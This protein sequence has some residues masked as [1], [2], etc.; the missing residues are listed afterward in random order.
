MTNKETGKELNHRSLSMRCMSIFMAATLTLSSVPALAY[1][2]DTP[3]DGMQAAASELVANNEVANTSATETSQEQVTPAQETSSSPSG[4]QSG[5]PA[6]SSKT[7]ITPAAT[8][9]A[10]DASAVVT[11]HD[12]NLL[13]AVCIALGKDYT[14]GVSVTE[15]DMASLTELKAEN[16][17]IKDLTGLYTYAVNLETLDLSGNDLSQAK[18]FQNLSVSKL[19]KMKTLD[20]SNCN[21]G[22]SSYAQIDSK[23]WLN[24][25]ESLES[26]D[27]SSNNL[28]GLLYL[29]YN[30]LSSMT[31]F[32]LGNLKQADF[33]KNNFSGFVCQSNASFNS[34]ERIDLSENRLWVNEGSKADGTEWY[35]YIMKVGY[36]KFDFLNQKPLTEVYSAWKSNDTNSFHGCSSKVDNASRTIDLGTVT[37]DSVTYSLSSFG[38]FEEL[39]VISNGWDLPKMVDNLRNQP[40]K[41]S[42]RTLIRWENLSEGE[43]T[44]E[45]KLSHASGESAVYT[46]KVTRSAMPTSTEESAGITD[47]NLH[48]SVCSALGLDASRAVTKGDMSKLTTLNAEGITNAEGIQYA[49]NLKSLELRGELSTLPDLGS[50]SSLTSLKLHGNYAQVT[51]L[52]KLSGLKT[53][54]LDGKDAVNAARN[55]SGIFGTPDL[56]GLTKLTA[57][58]VMST[59]MKTAPLVVSTTNLRNISISQAENGF[60]DLSS[61]KSKL[62]NLTLY[63]IRNNIMP[64]GLDF[65]DSLGSVILHSSDYPEKLFESFSLPRNASLEIFQDGGTVNDEIDISGSGLNMAMITIYN[66]AQKDTTLTIKGKAQDVLALSLVEDATTSYGTKYKLDEGLELNGLSSLMIAAELTDNISNKTIESLNQL[67]V[68]TIDSNYSVN[69]DSTIPAA[70]V[71][72]PTISQLTLAGKGSPL[73]FSGEV[74]FGSM[75]SLTSLTLVSLGSFLPERLPN[76][77]TTLSITNGTFSTLEDK[78][79][80]NVANLKTLQLKYCSIKDFPAKLVRNNQGLQ[81]LEIERGLFSEIPSDAFES[82][83]SL[84]TVKL[85]NWLKLDTDE[86]GS[87][88]PIAG[89]STQ[90]AIEALKENCPNAKVTYLAGTEHATNFASL[91]SITSEQGVVSGDPTTNSNLALYVPAG[92]R[93]VSFVVTGLLEDTSITVNGKE[94]KSGDVITVPLNSFSESVLIETHNDFVN[95]LNLS[96]DCVYSLDISQGSV[97]DSFVP[98]DGGVY[99]VSSSILKNGISSLSMAD[100]YFQ[101]NVTVRYTANAGAGKKYDIRVTTTKANWITDS[102]YQNA[103]GEYV[104]ADIVENNNASNTRVYRIYAASLDKPI[105]VS[106][107]VVPMGGDYPICDLS[108]DLANVVDISASAS[109]DTADLNAA[110]NKALEITEKNNVYTTDSW[111]ALNKALEQAQKIAELAVPTQVN[112]NAAKNALASAIDGLEVDESKLADKLALR[113]TIDDAKAIQKG[114]HTD[115]A[116]NALQE[117]IADAEGVFNTLEARQDEVDASVRSLNTAV[118]LFNSSGDASTLDKNNLKDGIYSITADMI[119]TDRVSK[120]MADNAINHTAKLEVKDG[121]YFITL[122]FRGITIENRFGYLKDLSYYTEGYT[123]GNYG[124]IEGDRVAAEVL[125]TQKDSDGN[126]VIDQYNDANSLYPDMVK[127]KLAPSAIAD[128]DG[129]V[130]LHV[131]VPIMESIATGNG[132]QDVLMKLDWSTLKTASADDPSFKPEDPIEQSPTVDVTDSATGVKVHADKGVFAEGTAIAV[133]AITSG[134]EHNNATKALS[135]VGKKFSFYKLQASDADGNEIAPNGPVSI[136]LPIPSG[137]DASKLAVYRINADGSKTLIQG[138]AENGLYTFTTRAMANFALVEKACATEL[139]S[140]KVNT[141]V[142]DGKNAIS[143]GNGS[144]A[145]LVALSGGSGSLSPVGGGSLAPID[146]EEGLIAEDENALASSLD[147]FNAANKEAGATSIWS[148]ILPALGA[149]LGLGLIGFILAAIFRRNKRSE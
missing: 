45:L 58:T 42:G 66:Q 140:N 34:L 107:C 119:K 120:S 16:A 74:D 77:L 130:P 132:D 37:T 1:A 139:G 28:S 79:Y 127:I 36:E 3:E 142:A 128:A 91:V 52:N 4:E 106:P 141:N 129:Y 60:P 59:N 7:S 85:G 33:S 32:K 89:S 122:D 72:K 69:G 26:I 9:G 125:S 143:K 71:C 56:S 54:V 144:R 27:L 49:T 126:D 65:F 13:K 64:E 53:L 10:E 115:T 70:L 124:T 68:L 61:V 83:S 31:P 17:G 25:F 123:Y 87:W 21:L 67:M 73:T 35:Q 88:S 38:N 41:N 90:A 82:S 136:S 12:E 148:T 102:K 76:S 5:A 11:F 40:S 138:K 98:S 86:S 39:S 109:V 110:I 104:T 15:N 117:A 47:P 113:T 147:E 118:T 51:G 103:E 99:N 8:E 30:D 146:E 46:L 133:S 55:T 145:S 57:L 84:R 62:R 105:K 43:N 50:L 29:G 95:P 121:E 114:N 149:V 22:G 94:Y 18:V 63:D 78:D 81:T 100:S 80:S 19:K 6:A 20:L 112:V 23:G 134:S 44:I 96:T 14:E 131:F 111:S 75:T 137:Y 97:M 135:D 108:L 2:T 92:T 93:E 101:K 24:N 116:W 48:A